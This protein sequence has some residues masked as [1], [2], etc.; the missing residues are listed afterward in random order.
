MIGPS[1]LGLLDIFFLIQNENIN[2]GNLIF[3]FILM[4]KMQKLM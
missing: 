4:E 2:L 1:V 3:L